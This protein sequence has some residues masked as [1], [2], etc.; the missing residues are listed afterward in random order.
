MLKN[1]KEFSI[2]MAFLYIFY[3]THWTTYVF[4]CYRMFLWSWK[5]IFQVTL[6]HGNVKKLRE[7]QL[8][9]RLEAWSKRSVVDPRDRHQGLQVGNGD[10]LFLKHVF[11]ACQWRGTLGSALG[12]AGSFAHCLVFLCFCVRVCSKNVSLVFADPN[13]VYRSCIQHSQQSQR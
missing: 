6:D 2:K 12:D 3:L 9:R 4:N 8:A 11:I 13:V 10:E 1:K 5:I 7:T